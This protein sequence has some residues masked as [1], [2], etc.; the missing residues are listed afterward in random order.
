LNQK[1]N[2]WIA[3]ALTFFLQPLGL[4]YVARPLLALMLFILLLALFASV[5]LGYTTEM[6]K[7]IATLILVSASSALAYRIAAR[8][9]GITPRPHYARWYG[10]VAI[11]AVSIV[12][13][14]SIRMF[15]YEP[16][17]APSGSMM[18]T[19][20]R[21]SHIIAKK[22]GYGYYGTYGFTLTRQPINADIRRGD[23]MVFEYPEDRKKFF[24]KRVIGLQGDNVVYREKKL[25]V[26]GRPISSRDVGAYVPNINDTP[27]RPFK[28]REE[29]LDDV[30]YNILVDDKFPTLMLQAVRSFEMRKLCTYSDDGFTCNVPQGHY[31]M[32][33]DSRDNADDS[34]YWGFVP[35]DAIVGKIEYIFAPK[36]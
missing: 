17:R 19:I 11:A 13:V 24:V 26:N 36:S 7:N 15:F 28:M 33:G 4:L 6:S 25:V 16:F 18:P 29:S 30:R 20:P 22:W 2:K 27:Q 35:A 3:A 31:F 8:S 12:I 1:P 10:L 9:D 5:M 21:E 34:R 23:I 14:V 32:M